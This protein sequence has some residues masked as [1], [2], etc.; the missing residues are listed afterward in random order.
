MGATVDWIANYALIL[1]FPVAQASI[2]LAG[3]MV[4]FAVLSVFAI[5]FIARFLPET[6]ELPVEEVIALFERQATGKPATD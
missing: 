2:G 1:I 6:K 5:L 3:V 4:A